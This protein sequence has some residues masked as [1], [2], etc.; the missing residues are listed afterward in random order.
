MIRPPDLNPR[1][2][3]VE[4][5]TQRDTYGHQL[6]SVQ[7]FDIAMLPRTFFNQTSVTSRESSLFRANDELRPRRDNQK[8]VR[9]ESQACGAGG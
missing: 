7:Q 2:P 4:V 6:Q 9:Q 3:A 8:G 1:T 5:D